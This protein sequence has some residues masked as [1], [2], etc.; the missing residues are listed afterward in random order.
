MPLSEHEQRLLEQLEQ[1]LHNEDPKLASTLGSG[2]T[3][4]LAA[5]HIVLGSLVAVAGVLVLLF[6]ISS[7]IIVLGVLGFLIMGAGIYWA[8]SRRRTVP[9]HGGQGHGGA[10][11]RP[12]RSAFMTSLEERW[13]ERR[14]DDS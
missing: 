5:R 8:S 2:A 6:G 3:R 1:Q 13:D 10:S 12:R 14:R 7:Q 9:D 11:A 4:S